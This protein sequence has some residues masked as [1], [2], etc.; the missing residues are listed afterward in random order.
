MHRSLPLAAALLLTACTAATPTAEPQR[1]VG[2]PAQPTPP[3]L[4]DVA[5]E[6]PF[7]ATSAQG[8][9][10]VVQIYYALIEAKNYVEAHKLWTTGVG[11]LA[12]ETFA[13]QFSGYREYHAEVFAPGAIEGAA[14]SLYVEVPVRTYGLTTKGEKFEEP[15]VVTLRRVNNVPGATAEQLSWRIMKISR[16]PAPH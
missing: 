16:P 1:P 12:D 5:S 13:D 2:A 8:A 14:G 15:A 11:D 6:P 7:T 10:Q 3:P 9:A 4:A